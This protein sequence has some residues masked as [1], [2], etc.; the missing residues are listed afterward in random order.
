M[1]ERVKKYLQAKNWNFVEQDAVLKMDVEGE[2]GSWVSFLK[3]DQKDSFVCFGV[4][5]V[6]VPEEKLVLASELTNLINSEIWNGN[7]E[8]ILT[9]ESKGQLRVRTAAIVP[10]EIEEEMAQAIIAATIGYNMV[11]MNQYLPLFLRAL[12][13]ENVTLEEFLP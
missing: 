7:F 6:R 5:P 8:L 4:L 13:G 1:K 11:A 3:V 9:G 10:Q 2:S 12:Y